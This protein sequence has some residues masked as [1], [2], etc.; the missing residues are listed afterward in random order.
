MHV[1]LQVHEYINKLQ[2]DAY[3]RNQTHN[4]H[5]K[6]IQIQFICK[7]S[8]SNS[9]EFTTDLELE[10][11]CASMQQPITIDNHMHAHVRTCA[12]SMMNRQVLVRPRPPNSRSLKHASKRFHFLQDLRNISTIDRLVLSTRSSERSFE[13]EA[14]RH[15]GLTPLLELSNAAATDGSICTFIAR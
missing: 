15:Q 5:C 13:A 2:L 8:A 4:V 7:T 6:F 9:F 11:Q 10:I 12:R 3:A 1:R 14:R